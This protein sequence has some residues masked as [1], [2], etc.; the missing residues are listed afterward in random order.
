MGQAHGSAFCPR[1]KDQVLTIAK[2]PSHLV[3]FII[4]VLGALFYWPLALLWLIVW[5]LAAAM[6]HPRRCTRCG[7]DVADL[8]RIAALEVR[9]A[10]FFDAWKSWSR[11]TDG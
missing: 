5:I 11:E 2:G 10:K 3:H 4:V 8:A 1:C 7:G 6:R 9:R